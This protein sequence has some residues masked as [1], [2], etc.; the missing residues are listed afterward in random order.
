[1]VKFWPKQL[2]QTH[3]NHPLLKSS[4][5]FKTMVQIFW[6][7]GTLK[8]NVCKNGSSG[9][10]IPAQLCRM[11]F[12]PRFSGFQSIR[13]LTVFLVRNNPFFLDFVI[14]RISKKINR[15]I[16]KTGNGYFWKEVGKERNLR[17]KN[18][19]TV[20]LWPVRHP[21]RKRL[22]ETVGWRERKC[23]GQR[24]DPLSLP[25]SHRPIS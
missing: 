5:S 8:S 7:D 11:R 14:N 2:Y 19:L 6:S 17:R 9:R 25:R 21:A 10:I 12:W 4:L 13:Q 23:R 22:K 15:S 1:M 16:K 20:P 24:T 3:S 18:H